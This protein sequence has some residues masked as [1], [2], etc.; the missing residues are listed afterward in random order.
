MHKKQDCTDPAAAIMFRPSRRACAITLLVLAV[1]DITWASS[2]CICRK[3]IYTNS[4]FVAGV[5]Y[6]FS[7]FQTKEQLMSWMA[8]L[9]MISLGNPTWWARHVQSATEKDKK[10]KSKAN[11]RNLSCSTKH[12]VA[13]AGLLRSGCWFTTGVEIE[14]VKYFSTI[15][16]VLGA[17]GVLALKGNNQISKEEG[18]VLKKYYE[19]LTLIYTGEHKFFYGTKYT[20]ATLILMAQ[21]FSLGTPGIHACLNFALLVLPN[22]RTGNTS[23]LCLFEDNIIEK[24]LDLYWSVSRGVRRRTTIGDNFQEVARK[25]KAVL[26]RLRSAADSG[27]VGT[28]QLVGDDEDLGGAAAV[29]FNAKSALLSFG[30]EIDTATARIED[31]KGVVDL[32]IRVGADVKVLDS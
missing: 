23:F 28:A 22:C 27:P 18:S 19:H 29:P 2:G 20:F 11:F 10:K 6:I 12:L 15:A 13:L 3:D 4:R 14:P 31:V 9:T 30:G 32:V 1:L 5:V 17:L 21:C 24:A 7:Q 25:A 26:E 8:A 16:V